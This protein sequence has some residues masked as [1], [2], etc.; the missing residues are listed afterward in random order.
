[1]PL[2]LRIPM[3]KEKMLQIA[4]QKAGKTKTGF[5]IEAIDEKLGLLKTREQK[6]RDLAGW[7][8]HDEAEE[9]RNSVNEFNQIHEGDWP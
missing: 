1:M 5:I 9:L 8:T 2:S 3:E 6:I 4:S 7:L